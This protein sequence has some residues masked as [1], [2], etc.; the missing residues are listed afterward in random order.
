[1]GSLRCCSRTLLTHGHSSLLSVGGDPLCQHYF[2]SSMGLLCPSNSSLEYI[3]RDFHETAKP[4][5]PHVPILAWHNVCSFPV[6]RHL[7]QMPKPFRNDGHLQAK[8]KKSL[9]KAKS[10][11]NTNLDLEESPSTVCFAQC[12]ILNPHL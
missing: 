7:P 4:V 3:F 10:F 5:F 8:G 11:T 2:Y 9:R 12:M 6:I 1:M